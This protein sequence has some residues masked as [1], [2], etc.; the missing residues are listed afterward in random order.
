M[1]KAC[2]HLSLYFCVVPWT[3]A[4][5]D[6]CCDSWK[7]NGYLWPFF[8]LCFGR[9]CRQVHEH[10]PQELVMRPEFL[11]W[12][13]E[14]S[15]TTN[16]SIHACCPTVGKP[17]YVTNLYYRSCT[18]V[19]LFSCSMVVLPVCAVQLRY[20]A[21]ALPCAS[22]YKNVQRISSHTFCVSNRVVANIWNQTVFFLWTR[23]VVYV[24]NVWVKK[25]EDLFVSKKK[26]K[27]GSSVRGRFP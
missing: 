13:G 8:P 1:R 11:R 6:C 22:N 14:I 15:I 2:C 10:P 21:S 5:V 24:Y 3:M 9:V 26:N 19:H 25:T 20:G 27:K 4:L 23:T 12:Q 18:V 17:A 16:A 7:V